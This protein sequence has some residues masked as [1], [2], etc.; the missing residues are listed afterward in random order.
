MA[1]L[2]DLAE[3]QD[4]VVSVGQAQAAGLSFGQIGR[5][6]RCG[7]YRRSRRG[8]VQIAGV[9]PTWRQAVR[10]ASIA[11][12]AEVVVSH[13]SAVRLYGIELPPAVHPRWARDNA[14]IE[15]SAPLLRHVRLDGVRG[16][17]SR[18]WA[19]DDVRIVAGMAVTSPVR[20]VIDMSSRLG[21]DGTGRL[22]DDMLRRRLITMTELCARLEDL[23]PAPG[24]SVRVLRIVAAGRSLTFDPGE[25][26]LEARIRRV[27]ERKGF[28]PPV[29]QH[30]VRDGTFKVR[31]DFAYPE[32]KVYLEGDGFGFH[33]FA[34]DLDKDV[35]KRNGLLERGWVG[36]HFTARMTSAEIEATLAR[37]YDRSAR[38]WQV[39][40]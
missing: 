17:R 32:V 4:G 25:S 40:R 6:R 12:G 22:V 5:R 11:A 20:V 39:P 24:R 1:T 14:F 13:A 7:R 3:R 35:R 15:V 30:W 33:R 10:M 19:T 28:P 18:M 2:E 26:K 23:R 38:Q 16:H 29:G 27:V 37:F 8:V 9:P 34:S 36:L 31:L 21:V